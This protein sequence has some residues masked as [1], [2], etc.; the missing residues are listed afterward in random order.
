MSATSPLP[1]VQQT[2]VAGLAHVARLHADR[3]AN[4]ILAGALKRVADWQAQRLR[5]TYAD[6]AAQ[7][8]YLQAIEFFETDLYG[9]GD[10]AQRDAD[11]ARVMPVMAR[12]LPAGVIGTVGKAVLLNALSQE[13]DRL[14]LAR[15]PRPDGHFSVAEYCRAFRRMGRRPERE[16]QIALIG[17]IGTAL[18]HYVDK[19]LIHGA[20]KMMRQPARLA[21]LE[22]LQH[23]LERGVGAFRRMHGADEF[24]AT[25][26][27]RESALVEAMFAGETAPF[28]DPVETLRPAAP[29][30][31]ATAD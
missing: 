23:F 25:I 1:A 13:L 2:L 4:P 12:M 18:D 5:A 16:R 28:P 22:A 26:L 8:R 27:A 10:F 11:L 24:L 9:G 14:L 6:L 15:L 19:P 17:E 3:L 21:G 7:S 30:Q 29:R 20:L 31:Q